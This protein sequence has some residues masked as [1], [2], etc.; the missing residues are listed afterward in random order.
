MS[1]VGSYK[2]SLDAK[3]RV[4]IPAKFRDELGEEFYIPRKFDTYLS[5]YTAEDW[6]VYVDKIQQLPETV[7]IEVQDFLLGIA[8][9]CVPDASGRIILDERLAAHAG[10]NKNI[11]F[12]GGGRQIRIWAE[13]V[14]NERESKRDLAKIR[15]IMSQYGL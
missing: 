7:A 5:I 14:W 2:H 9:K 3:K 6:E 13:E 15:E 4:F 1:F 12:V 8:Q 11:V 10:I